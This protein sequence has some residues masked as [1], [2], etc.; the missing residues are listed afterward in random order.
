MSWSPRS[1][2]SRNTAPAWRAFRRRSRLA[3]I[4]ES[5]KIR[6]NM[7]P[8]SSTSP[9]ICAGQLTD[10]CSAARSGGG[11]RDRGSKNWTCPRTCPSYARS[12]LRTSLA[13]DAAG[14]TRLKVDAHCRETGLDSPVPAASRSR[15][16]CAQAC[17]LARVRTIAAE[18]SVGE[19]FGGAGQRCDALGV[20]G[21]SHSLCDP[22]RRF[23][24]YER[25]ASTA[26][27]AP[28]APTRPPRQTHRH[29]H[30]QAVTQWPTI[31]RNPTSKTQACGDRQPEWRHS[32][33]I[34]GARR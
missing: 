3:G 6:E 30:P 18:K 32:L 9:V 10:T 33:V 24:P 11:L 28:L 1:T 29:R 25:V 26:L 23:A 4:V 12:A 27:G 16:W 31:T 13:R 17:S 5:R 20:L 7:R 8:E 15:Q 14:S 2:T 22:S 21:E 34:S 19:Q